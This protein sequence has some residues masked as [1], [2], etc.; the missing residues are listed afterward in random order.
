[1]CNMA[2]FVIT[3]TKVLWSIRSDSHEDIIA[4]YHLRN[5]MHGD[6]FVRSE[7]HPPDYDYRLPVDQWIYVTDQDSTPDWYDPRDAEIAVRAEMSRW[8]EVKIIND[9]KVKINIEDGMNRIILAGKVIQFGGEC[10]MYGSSSNKQSGGACWMYGSSTNRQSGGDCT[11]HDSSSNKQSDG[12]CWMYESA[13]NKQSGGQCTMYGSSTNE[14]SGG[15]CYMRDS[16]SNK[17]SNGQCWM[18]G[19]ASNKQSGGICWMY[20]SSSNEQSGGFCSTY[21]PECKL[22]KVNNLNLF[23]IWT[24]M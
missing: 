1:M 17:Q 9:P 6:D 8:C 14:Q 12:Q 11:I 15:E 19:S 2:S 20:Y 16:S 13:S 24:R 4:M 23:N 3:R 10:T 22:T 21:G 18:Y 7:L 5:D